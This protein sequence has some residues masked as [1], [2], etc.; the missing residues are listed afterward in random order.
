MGLDAYVRHDFKGVDDEIESTELW[1]G[2]KENEI[3]GWMQRQ[4]GVLANDFNCVDFEL[5]AELLDEFE[6]D[7]KKGMLIPT[8]G[9]FFGSGNN[10]ESVTEEATK[11]LEAARLSLADGNT[12][13]YTSWW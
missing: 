6:D 9:F 3:H 4:S 12:P 7:L 13:Y 1:Y 8:S 11:L 5:T 10:Q 2:R